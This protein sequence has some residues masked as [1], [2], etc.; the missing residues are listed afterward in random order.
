MKTLETEVLVCGGGCAGLCAALASARNGAKTLLVERAGFSGGIITAVGLPY[1]DGIAHKKDRKILLGGI[2]VELLV[3]SEIIKAG[4]RLVP[5]YN[6]TIGNIERFKRLADELL[7]AEAPRLSVLYHTQ[8]CDV[9]SEPDRIKE[10]I[11]ANKDGLVA[12]RAHTVIDT[13]GDGDVAA[14]GGAPV[15]KTSPLQPMTMHFRFGHVKKTPE[16]QKRCKAELVA[17]QEAGELSMFYG[18]G[19]MFMFAPDE[20]YVHASRIKGDAS[21]AADLTRCEIEGRAQAWAMFS[22][23]KKN[24]PGFE[25]AYFV[26]SGPYVGVRE[27]RRIDGEYVLTE[28]DIIAG[29]R[30]DDAVATGCWYLDIHPN[31]TTTGSAWHEEPVFPEPYDIPYGSIQAKKLGNL[32]VAGRCHSATAKA[33]SSTRVT[34][35]AMALGQA[36]GTAAALAVEGKTSVAELKGLAVRRRLESQHAGPYV[37]G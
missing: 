29:R 9:R 15:V 10:V 4:D 30:F 28:D 34:C 36:A 17:A 11:V 22:R 21:D 13:T 19:L 25:D 26:T 18:P 12:I 2:P 33:A 20:L 3:R 1:F 6:P 5:K 35:T 37:P 8:V 14:F 23:W 31:E 7:V 24:V 32:L 16:M 27:T